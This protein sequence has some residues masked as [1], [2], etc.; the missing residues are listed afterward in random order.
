MTNPHRVA[1]TGSTGL[2]G[3]ALVEALRADGRD[4][5]RFVRREVTA[6]DEIAWDPAGGLIDVDAMA[7]I[8]A[9][10]H[11]AGAGVGDH[12]WTEAYKK[13]IR[14]SR[15][16]GTSTLARALAAL[17]TPPATFLCGSAVGYY[18]DTGNREVDE[19]APQGSGFLADV[20]RDWEAAAAPARAAGI[21]VVHPRS[22]LVASK[23]G[24]AWGRMFPLFKLG[25][26]GRLGSGDQYWSYIS[27]RDEVSALMFLLDTVESGSVR[28]E[29]PVNL[30]AP[31]P[32]TNREV[33]A[34]MR[35]VLHR[36]ALLPVPAFALDAVL[37]EFSNEVIG[38]IRAVPRKLL[39]AG[40]EF[41]DDTI[42][43][44]IEAALAS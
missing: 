4:V 21:R 8:D 13:T 25:V 7:G 33:T 42:D 39:D 10:V 1:I 6:S 41:Q 16:M 15:V 12:R 36:P 19:S 26:G 2:I 14:D 5:L 27:L 3:S 34:A 44:A 18:G 30:S 17:S 22:G 38:S 31:D 37:G 9:V 35:R 32:V 24:G 23:K 11:L 28:L 43:K 20:V 29:G 40:F